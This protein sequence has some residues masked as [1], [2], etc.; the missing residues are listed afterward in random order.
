MPGILIGMH[1]LIERIFLLLYFN[2]FVVVFVSLLLK[3]FIFVFWN[4]FSS[5]AYTATMNE[6]TQ[7]YFVLLRRLEQ[8]VFGSK[9]IKKQQRSSSSRRL[10][11]A[12]VE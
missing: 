10:V 4:A 7:H 3:Y 8:Q 11:G 9:N 2:I 1:E 6:R 5:V 12:G